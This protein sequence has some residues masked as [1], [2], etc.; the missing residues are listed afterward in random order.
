MVARAA[1]QQRVCKCMRGTNVDACVHSLS[2]AHLWRIG[3]QQ[4]GAQSPHRSLVRHDEHLG[5]GE[6]EPEGE[7]ESGDGSRD[8]GEREGEGEGEGGGEGEGEG[9]GEHV[10]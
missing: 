9:G 5:K 4:E 10:A 3:R 1:G 7:G 8:K 6:G 2:L